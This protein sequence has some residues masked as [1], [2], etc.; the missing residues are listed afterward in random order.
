MG[1]YVKMMGDDENPLESGGPSAPAYDPKKAFN[2]K[3]IWVR[4]LIVFAGPGMNF[5]LAA[6]IFAAVFMTLGRPVLI[7]VI[8]RVVESG[9][10]A[11]AGLQ[12]GDRIVK[13]GD[14]PVRHWDEVGR[15]VQAAQGAP[16]EGRE[17]RPLAMEVNRGGAV[18]RVT[19]TPV[20]GTERDILG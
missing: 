12:P 19:V 14:Q 8:G 2:T 20:K 13:V 6:A 3:P 1:G 16:G 11:A 17:A 15:A 18:Q 9:P 5:V 10:A 7:A 4:F